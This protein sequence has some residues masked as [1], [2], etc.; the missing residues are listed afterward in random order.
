[1]RRAAKRYRKM[2]NI[3]AGNEPPA[4]KKTE[5]NKKITPHPA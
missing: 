4:S 3:F 2:T 1:M 5:K